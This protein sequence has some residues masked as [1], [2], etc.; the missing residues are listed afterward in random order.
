MLT[1]SV[2]R[3]EAR[4]I[5]LALLG[6]R[7]P[8][9]RYRSPEIVTASRPGG[10]AT[11]PDS[12]ATDFS[13]PG[14]QRND[15]YHHRHSRPSRRHASAHNWR[16]RPML[17][18]IRSSKNR[19]LRAPRLSASMRPWGWISGRFPPKRLPF[20]A[21]PGCANCIAAYHTL[22]RFLLHVKDGSPLVGCRLPSKTIAS[23]KRCGLFWVVGANSNHI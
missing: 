5:P 10:H 1:V 8:P 15:L 2:T 20:P 22:F 7:S 6:E 21:P 16:S 14:H 17:N 23:P 3:A 12:A 9:G 4:S 11:H 13:A 19:A 18:V